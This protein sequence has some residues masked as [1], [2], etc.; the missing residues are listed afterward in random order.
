MQAGKLMVTA[1]VVVLFL[2]GHAAATDLDF[3][4]SVN[5]DP[6][7]PYSGTPANGD[8]FYPNTNYYGSY[9]TDGNTYPTWLRRGGTTAINPLTQHSDGG[10]G[11]TPD[12]L[13][14]FPDTG[15]AR[16]VYLDPAYGDLDDVLYMPNSAS[17]KA[18]PLSL[19]D[20]NSDIAINPV[21]HSFDLAYYQGGTLASVQV[22]TYD[23]A[24]LTTLWSTTD[25]VFAE[26]GHVTFDFGGV[27]IEGTEQSLWI[28]YTTQAAEPIYNVALDN[29]IFSQTPE[30][31]ALSLIAVGGL[32]LLR[33]R[34]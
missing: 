12:I 24:N 26:N 30:P 21:L 19:S 3:S 4:F 8:A 17:G 25:V 32:A 7:S 15:I 11:W 18:Y 22:E 34:R 6:L 9:I 13:V 31:T 27:P 20:D 10:V 1:A 5:P 29:V 33:R 28:S 2:V 16:S 23:G 14:T